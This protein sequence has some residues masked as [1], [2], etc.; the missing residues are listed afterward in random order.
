M[1]MFCRHNRMTARCPIC[2]REAAAQARASAP[3]RPPRARS[4]GGGA[5][6]TAGSS[7]QPS[8]RTRR[9][10]RAPDDGYRNP[11]V[12]GI[13]ATAD[14]E[15]L[16]RA[17]TAAAGR[18]EF[19][20][21]HPE[22]AEASREEAIGLAFALSAGAEHAD[23]FADWVAR[24]GGDA[25]TALTGDETWSPGRRFARLFERLGFLPRAAR[26]EFLVTL[27]ASAGLPFEADALHV[28]SDEDAATTAAKRVLLSGDRTL[29]ER[30]AREL[31]SAC[32]VPL[33][34]LDHALAVWEAGG[35]E[36]GGEPAPAVARAL[37]V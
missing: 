35:P 3:G 32:E 8:L 4:A 14:A 20:G 15:R 22:A 25:Q 26:Y 21:P 11:L 13:R 28:G 16:A 2:S 18:L 31:A 29:L 34:A 7:R 9:L 17:L 27:G 10:E 24:N 19:P 23:A 1:S 5:R 36:D 12:P 33:A 37:R 6:R 30:R